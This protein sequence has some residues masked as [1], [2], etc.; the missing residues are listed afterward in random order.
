MAIIEVSDNTFHSLIEDHP[1]VVLDFWATWC[2]PCRAFAPIFAAAAE[3]YP[4]VLFGKVD[5]DRQRELAKGF[6]IRSVPTL[7]VLRDK[8]VVVRE[9]GALAAASLEK[10]MQHVLELDMDAVRSELATQ[11]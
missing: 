11:T 9:S 3:K 10:V 6:D 5:V 8:I 1:V 7:M 4:D 2:G